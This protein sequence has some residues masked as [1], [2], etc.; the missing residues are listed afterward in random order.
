VSEADSAEPASTSRDQVA[1]D[2]VQF[3]EA[4]R[5]RV[6]ERRADGGNLAVLLIE[7]GVISRI[8]AVWGYRIGDAVRDRV[9]ASLRTDVL[10]PS[11][12][13]GEMGRDDFACV[14]S[15]VEGPAVALLAAR[16]SLRAL[17]TP[18]WIGE[19]EIYASPSIGIAMYPAHGDQAEVL[20]QQAKSACVI[21][22]DLTGHIA[23]YADDR[24]NPAAS[25]FLFENRLR[26]A[27]AEDALELAFQPQYDLRR[28]QV[29]GA[30]GLLR[31]R[32]P[33]LGMI[34]SEH[35]FAAAESADMVTDLVSSILNRA[36]RNVSE[37]RYSAGLDLRIGIKLPARALRHPE[38]SDVVE[39]ALGTW[40]RRAGTLI[41][42]IGETSVL[43]A[44]GVAKETLGRLK[45]LGVKLSID[46]AGMALSSL[47][48][49]ASLPFQEIKIDVSAARDLAGAPKSER[50][51]QSIIEL[52]HHLRLDVVA[53]GV[54]DDAAAARLKELGCD[55]MQADYKGP[56][57]DPKQFVERFGFNED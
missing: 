25:K 16:K 7:C 31:W 30:E 54:A 19:D 49:L 10:R 18:F 27:V 41:L 46:D 3:L 24:D 9:A 47:F 38:L 55:Y 34:A 1:A 57:L 44:D 33:T 12:L 32:D 2:A 42:E 8:D 23:D 40:S 17:N 53:V 13:V 28:G 50:I 5:G 36:L 48:W 14:L 39:R 45:E 51:V 56:A 4:L 29:M 15:A 22:R 21:A 37:F 52:A 6:E 20:L 35:A 11:D 26:T 43:G